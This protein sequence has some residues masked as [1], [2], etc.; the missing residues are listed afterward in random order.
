MLDIKVLFKKN[1]LNSLRLKKINIP[2]KV[3]FIKALF[4]RFKMTI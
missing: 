4:Q 1:K 3:T 2:C